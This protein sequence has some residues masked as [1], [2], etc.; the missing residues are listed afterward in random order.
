MSLSQVWTSRPCL[1]IYAHVLRSPIL[2]KPKPSLAL[3]LAFVFVFIRLHAT[4]HFHMQQ[5]AT[6][7]SHQDSEWVS[8]M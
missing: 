6:A 1:V 2:P 3:A 7:E 4:C 8:E 5:H